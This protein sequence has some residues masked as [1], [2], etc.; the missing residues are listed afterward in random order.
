MLALA[1]AGSVAGFIVWNFPVARIFM[2]DAGSGFLGITIGLMILY[3]AK[4]DSRVLIA[5][6]CLLGVFIVDATTTLLRRLLAGKQVYE[7]HA[8]H[9]YQILDRNIL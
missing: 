8:S 4:L 3:F 9:C 1:L 6:L 7:A 2:G 5:E